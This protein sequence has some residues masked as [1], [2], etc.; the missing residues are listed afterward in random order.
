MG[1]I[2]QSVKVVSPS[3]KSDG[4]GVAAL[5]SSTLVKTIYQCACYR[6]FYGGSGRGGYASPDW[7]FS[8]TAN[9]V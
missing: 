9:P 8:G 1:Q 5:D 7:M 4:Q 3:A 6:T 2:I